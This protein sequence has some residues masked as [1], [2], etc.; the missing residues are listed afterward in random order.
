M[1]LISH[2]I[3]TNTEFFVWDAVV[4]WSNHI[5]NTGFYNC[6]KGNY[7]TGMLKL[8]ESN[9]VDV[10]LKLSDL[11]DCW[12]AD[13]KT[14]IESKPDWAAATKAVRKTCLNTFFHFAKDSFDKTQ[15]PYQRHPNGNEIEFILSPA[16]D[17]REK[18]QS[19]D[20]AVMRHVLS[21]VSDKVRA[22]DICPEVLCTALSKLN[23]RDAYIVWLMMYTGQ[24]L[25]NVLDRKKENLKA[26]FMSAEEA[27]RNRLD[28]NLPHAYGA[29]LDFGNDSP[30]IPGHI[31]DGINRVSSNSKTFLFET[32]KGKRITRVQVTRNL[33][34]AGHAIGL[35]FDLTPKILHGYVC[36]YLTA[37]K[38]SIL[39]K[40]LGLPNY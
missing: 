40:G 1:N 31:V 35:T 18:Y 16:F 26:S 30:H 22:R 9:I 38:R 6:S 5:R 19:I 15:I 29:Y 21:N 2:L 34:Q 20:Q 7:L 10:R 32:A 4:A 17:D 33:K 25:E 11:D 27:L 24:P 14:K 3:P 8:I 28:P 36:A 39:E 23:E 37:D 13:C 12:L